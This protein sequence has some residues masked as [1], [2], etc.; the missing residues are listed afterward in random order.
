[1]LLLEGKTIN[2]I[3]YMYEI[4]VNKIKNDIFRKYFSVYFVRII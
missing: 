3:E 1:M 2:I 4:C